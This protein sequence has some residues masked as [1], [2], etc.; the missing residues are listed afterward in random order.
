M[1]FAVVAD[2][3]RNLAQRSAQAARDTAG[4]IEESIA[5]SNDGGVRLSEVVRSMATI[6]GQ[7][8]K[9]RA[10]VDE[11]YT[12]SQEQSRGAQEISRALSRIEQVT[13]Q[14]AAGA[15]QGAAA[16]QELNNQSESLHGVIANLGELVGGRR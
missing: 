10:L 1:G 9:V 6:T 3:V 13:Q 16:A 12:A 2:E 7:T 11:I 5:R 14:T 15:E 4:L 8:A